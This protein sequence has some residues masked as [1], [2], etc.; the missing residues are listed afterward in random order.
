MKQNQGSD[1]LFSHSKRTTRKLGG[2]HVD[3][4]EY[5]YFLHTHSYT[6]IDRCRTDFP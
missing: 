4:Q 1:P 5:N 6:H 2:K 3:T